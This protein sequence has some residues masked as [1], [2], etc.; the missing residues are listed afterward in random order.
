MSHPYD[1]STKYL[2]ENRLA[3]WLPLCGRVATGPVEIVSAD[4]STVT[5]AA[6]RALRVHGDPPWLLHTELQSS[7]DPDLGSSAHLYNA[8]LERQYGAPVQSLMVLLRRSADSPDLTGRLERRFPGESPYLAFEYR[9][10]RVWQMPPE[11]FLKGG[12]GLV[13]LAPLSNVAEAD[14][15]TL[16]EQ[17]DERIQQEADPEEAGT[18]WTAADV[19]M[20][21]RYSRDLVAHLLRGIHG[22]KDSATYQAIVEEG[23]EKGMAKG[24]VLGI[25]DAILRFGRKRLGEPDK[26]VLNTLRGLTDLLRLERMADRLADAVSWQ[27]VLATP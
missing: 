2:V 4:L 8:L 7:R 17:M 25:Q 24:M 21:L 11:T 10:V 9:V 27:D 5:A 14:L 18:L 23:V 19:L 20:G 26:T 3:D 1:A 6:D 22:M 16:I 15:P 12:L 13:P